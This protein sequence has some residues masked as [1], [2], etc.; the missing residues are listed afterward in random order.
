MFGQ[1][2]YSKRWLIMIAL[3]FIFYHLSFGYAIAQ[4]LTARA[5]QQV[6]VGEQ[7]RLTYTVN[8]Q[9]VSGFR[10]GQ[11]PDAFEILMGPSTSSQSSFQM[12]N[13]KTSQSSSIT[14]TFILSA[15]KNETAK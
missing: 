3:S 14:Y 5:P 8:T 12:I 7:F 9:D 13:G 2:R 10:I 11:V 1:I 6:A 4:T 15:V